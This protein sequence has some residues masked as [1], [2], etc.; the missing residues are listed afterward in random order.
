LLGHYTPESCPLYLTRRGYDTLRADNAE[1][2][3]TFRLHTDSIVKS[4]ISLTSCSL[5]ANPIYISVLKGLTAWSLTRAV[6][7]DHLDWFSPG[8]T[9]V[10]EEVDELYRV[11]APGGF[12]FWRSA[13]R[14]PWYN[15]V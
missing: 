5:L 14:K 9:E 4:V 3:N 10:A 1:V 13:A 7:M 8:S 11:L 6:I 12:V 2:M 15:Q